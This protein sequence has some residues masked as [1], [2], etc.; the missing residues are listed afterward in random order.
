M[1]LERLVI[2]TGDGAARSLLLHP[3]LT[4]VAGLTAPVAA[5]LGQLLGDALR[6][7]TPGVHVD[8]TLDGGTALRVVR[9]ARG[10][11]ILID[12]RTGCAIAPTA[13]LEGDLDLS[14]YGGRSVH[15]GQLIEHTTSDHAAIDR[16]C[17][18]ADSAS[19]DFLA[20]VRALDHLAH[21]VVDVDIAAAAARAAAVFSAIARGRGLGAEPMPVIVGDVF[22]G[23]DAAIEPM[24]LDLLG[25]TALHG[26]VIVLADRE[27]V[28]SWA[29]IERLTGAVAV[30]ESDLVIS[31]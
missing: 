28:A 11:S 22:S 12:R 4:V 7:G 9:P 13:P 24:L 21:D 23:A 5:A 1:K 6:T 15:V 10:P 17:T 30:V 14:A 8:F 25:R 2:E 18:G 20:A 19:A 3:R 26:Q 27:S 16:L 31:N 29:R